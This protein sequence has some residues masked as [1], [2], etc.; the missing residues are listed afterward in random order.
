MANADAPKF[1]PK[2]YETSPS[3][4]LGG[5]EDNCYDYA[6][7]PAG[8][9]DWLIANPGETHMDLSLQVGRN[10][11][12]KH[13]T[14][15][16]V[17]DGLTPAGATLPADKPGFYVVGLYVAHGKDYHFIRQDAGGTWS[18]KI[19]SA[20]L[21]SLVTDNKNKPVSTP[22]ASL[23]LSPPEEPQNAKTYTLAQF[24]YVPKGGLKLGIQKGI[25]DATALK[26][27]DGFCQAVNTL[28][29]V[30]IDEKRKENPNAG[31][32][33]G[34]ELDSLYYNTRFI[35]VPNAN[36]PTDT[37]YD[38]YA[39]CCATKADKKLI[40]NSGILNPASPYAACPIP[41][42]PLPAKHR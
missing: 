40:F 22:P 41:N 24:F 13:V 33:I 42:K 12:A 19:G 4:P 6:V 8:K 23:T 39:K 1:D 32:N 7:E 17:K 2:P 3:T 18:Q 15:L 28:R 21:P 29:N 14:D 35:H 27:V 11:T 16:V 10:I 36:G 9:I 31:K 26:G 37:A 25:V 5:P 34:A 20:S 38:V 30:F